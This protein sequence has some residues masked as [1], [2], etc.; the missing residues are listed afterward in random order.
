MIGV[1]P[2]HV[3]GPEG[4]SCSAAD[5]QAMLDNGAYVEL[6]LGAPGWVQVIALAPSRQRGRVSVVTEAASYPVDPRGR[7]VR[8][9]EPELE[10]LAS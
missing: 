4:A 5:V 8:V 9:I 6:P 10:V 3:F 2:E 7:R 1:G